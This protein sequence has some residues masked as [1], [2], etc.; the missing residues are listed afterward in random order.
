MWD[1]AY[2]HCSNSSQLSE[3]FH[4]MVSQTIKIVKIVTIKDNQ[5]I[6]YT[7]A[8]HP[9]SINIFLPI[10]ICLSSTRNL[11]FTPIFKFFLYFVFII[12]NYPLMPF[13]CVFLRTLTHVLMVFKWTVWLTS[14][15]LSQLRPHINHVIY[16]VV[17][18]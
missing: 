11:F 15:L 12:N 14:R 17:C 9:I 6:L 1:F 16:F 4:Y 13:K 18:S 2:V 8:S 5:I 3:Y 7:F 10:S